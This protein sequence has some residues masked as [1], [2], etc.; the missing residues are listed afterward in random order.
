AKVVALR[1]VHPKYLFG[2]GKAAEMSGVVSAAEADAVFVNAPLSGQQQK[3]L[4][5]KWGGAN[6]L[7]RFR[8]ILDIF[9]DRARTNE[10]KLQARRAAEKLRAEAAHLVKG[11]DS[12]YDRQRGGLGAV[13]G[14]GE[15]AIETQR[16]QLR[17]RTAEVNR[18]LKGVERRRGFQRGA[19]DRR[20]EPTVALVGYTNVGKSSL[21]NQLALA[22]HSRAAGG[23]EGGETEEEGAKNRVFDTLDPTVR[24]VTLPSRAR[25][26]LVDTVGFIQ[27]LPT[28]LIHS[29]KSTLEEV[30]SADVLV[31]VRDASVEP[32]ICE[33][34]RKAVQETLAELG[35]GGVPTLEV[36]NKVDKERASGRG[37]GLTGGMSLPEEAEG[38]DAVTRATGRGEGSAD[39][40]T[41]STKKTGPDDEGAVRVSASTGQGLAL[42]L[43]KLDA[44]L[45]L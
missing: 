26:V 28:D 14:S 19:R 18:Q 10:A 24:S 16:R 1:S 42:L 38:E 30:K 41:P 36:W 2:S 20:L 15:K 45:H 9:A 7:D 35:A 31:H 17:D 6:V 25:C 4:A 39:T 34:Q 21:L 12:G 3:A 40:A 11:V 37:G 43:E 5:A 44:I 27:D 22:R 33:A 23:G 13:G 32:R 29:F 8:V